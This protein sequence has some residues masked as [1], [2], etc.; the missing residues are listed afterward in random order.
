MNAMRK[1]LVIARSA[2]NALA[3]NDAKTL[4]ARVRRAVCRLGFSNPVLEIGNL[5]FVKRFGQET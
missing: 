5:L 3:S 2:T 1:K 4:F